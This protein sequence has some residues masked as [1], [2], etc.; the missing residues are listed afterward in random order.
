MCSHLCV[1]N[2]CIAFDICL[3][4]YLNVLQ[5]C[6]DL[7]VMYEKPF[8]WARFKSTANFKL[9]DLAVVTVYWI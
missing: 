2:T 4:L 3:D 5:V 7:N 1:F 9:K 8:L 6:L